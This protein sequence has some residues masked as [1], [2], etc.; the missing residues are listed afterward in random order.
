MIPLAVYRMEEFSD[1]KLPY[2]LTNPLSK[3]PVVQG[4]IIL[5][6]GNFVKKDNS[7]DL[8]SRLKHNN[9]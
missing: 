4:D 8:F 9:L 3:A 7:Q 5:I 6:M 2:I 1:N